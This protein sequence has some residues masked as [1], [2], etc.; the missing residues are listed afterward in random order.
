MDFTDS[1]ICLVTELTVYSD[2]YSLICPETC[3]ALTDS[4]WENSGDDKVMVYVIFKRTSSTF[5]GA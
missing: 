1:N 2:L 5:N 4:A 3:T